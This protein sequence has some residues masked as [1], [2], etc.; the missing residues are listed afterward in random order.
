VACAA[1]AGA[2]QPAHLPL[3]AGWELSGAGSRI[4]SHH[5]RR[6]LLL[7]TGRAIRRDIALE[8][9]TIEFDMKVTP[10]RSFVY[11]QFRMVTDE[12]HEEIYFRPHKSSLP[13]AI[14]YTPVWRGESNW[15]LWH[16]PG[17]TAPA[18]FAAGQWMHVRLVMCGRRAALFLGDDPTPA[19]VM[20]LARDPAPGHIALRAFVPAGGAPEGA[21]AAA[22]ANVTVQPGHVPPDFERIIAAPPAA[23]DA[24]LPDAHGSAERAGLVRRWQLSPPFAVPAGPVTRLPDSLLASRTRWRAYAAEPTGVLVIGRHLQRP[25]PQSATIAR[26]VLPASADRLQRLDLGYS[27]F[28]TVFVNGRPIFA[29]DARYSFDAPRQEGLI[30]LSQAT[31][32]L[33]LVRGDNEILIAIADGFGG[34]GVMASLDPADGA[35]VPDARALPGP[36]NEPDDARRPSAAQSPE[37]RARRITFQPPP[38]RTSS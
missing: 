20:T 14:Q 33:P 38:A 8:D 22:I 6:A 37:R 16:G 1:N 21:P 32:W 28:A 36:R 24:R 35:A 13:D 7:R 12:E 4:E 5:G 9:G 18:R 19:L 3:D 10:H 25:A 29:G 31:V 17:A 2:Q 27:D 34:W 26:I 23:A 11:V 15:Q 30:A